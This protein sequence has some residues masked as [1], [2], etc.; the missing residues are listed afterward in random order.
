MTLKFK[1]GVYDY[2]GMGS[3]LYQSV[4]GDAYRLSPLEAQD[5]A[6][7]EGVV[8]VR[9]NRMKGTSDF[10]PDW[11][12]HVAEPSDYPRNYDP[13]LNQYYLMSGRVL[14]SPA[15]LAL[16]SLKRIGDD[17]NGYTQSPT[18]TD[19]LAHQI[20]DALNAVRHFAERL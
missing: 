13:T 2:S 4:D 1:P 6:Q 9:L 3:G 12:E 8:Y 20:V 17:S 14:M 11:R 18:E 5:R 16:A 7:A 15:G 19:A 10:T